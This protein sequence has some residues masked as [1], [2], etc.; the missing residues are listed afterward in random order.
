[1]QDKEID[2]IERWR[3]GRIGFHQESTNDVLMRH[4]PAVVK[5]PKCDVLVPLCGKSKD[6]LWLLER[7]HRV[8]GVE[9]CSIAVEAFFHENKVDYSVEERGPYTAYIGR[10]T[11]LKITLL[12]GDFFELEPDI[13]G[14]FMAVYDRAAFVALPPSKWPAYA[15]AV[16]RVMSDE[17]SGLVLTFDYPQVER[18]GPPF[19]VSYDDVVST[20]Q[21]SWSVDLLETLNLADRNRWELSRLQE[22]VI[23]IRRA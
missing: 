10:N 12:V 6:M 17:A 13:A 3:D 15:A 11:E 18:D 21:A 23:Q 4:W 7:G 20:L 22:P 2:W 19:S 8:V 1:M 9:L 14:R 5:D 16:T